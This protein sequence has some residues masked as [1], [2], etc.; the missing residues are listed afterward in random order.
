M[1]FSFGEVSSGIK[2]IIYLKVMADNDKAHVFYDVGSLM[3][4]HEI[5]SKNEKSS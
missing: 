5:S 3:F 2:A 1:L 4:L